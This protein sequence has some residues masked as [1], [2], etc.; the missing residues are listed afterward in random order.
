MANRILAV[1]LTSARLCVATAESTLRSLRVD[2]LLDIERDRAMTLSR[3]LPKHDYDRVIATVPST[4]ASFRLLEFAFRDKRRLDQAV[5]PALEEH[6]PMSLD[7]CVAAWDFAAQ[8][9]RGKI[10]GLLV[11]YATLDE[12]REALAKYEVN[13]QRFIWAPT[14]IAE[15][16]RRTLGT[17]SSYTAIDVS[18]DGAVLASFV[19]G[20]LDSLRVVGMCPTA[21]LVRNLAWSIRTMAPP[22]PRIVL[23]GSMVAGVAPALADLLAEFRLEALPDRCPLE[24]TAQTST[25][26]TSAAPVLGLLYAVAGNSGRPLVELPVRAAAQASATETNEWRDRLRPLAPWAALAA[27]LTVT[28]VTTNYVKLSSEHA[29]LE[30]QAD[31]IFKSAMPGATGSTGRRLKLEMRRDELTRQVRASAGGGGSTATPL[32]VLALMSQTIPVDLDIEFDSYLHEPPNVR[33]SGRASSFEAV[34]RVQELLQANAGFASVEV[35]DVRAA[36]NG[37]G[38]DF[39][40]MIKLAEIAG[41][42]A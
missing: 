15:V 35:R 11:P 40:M 16:Y 32:R 4:A 38:V 37:E 9:K 33:L 26:W 1:H 17:E 36:V 19:F 10:L 29:R 20:K 18:P 8:D 6:V 27:G 13:P 3:L 12:H 14:A 39:Q 7:E 5:G 23:G 41:G 22:T 28:A 2:A 34:T 24:I 42:Q 30:Q 21:V 25:H 31:T